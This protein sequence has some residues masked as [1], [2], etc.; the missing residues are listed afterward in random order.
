[1]GVRNTYVISCVNTHASH[2]RG[3]TV[4]RRAPT[5]GGVSEQL[6]FTMRCNSVPLCMPDAASPSTLSQ[7]RGGMTL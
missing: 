5:E 1:M 4:E 3:Y 6:A 7:R 2:K